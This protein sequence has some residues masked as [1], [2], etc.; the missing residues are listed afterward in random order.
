MKNKVQMCKTLHIKL[1]KYLKFVIYIY[2]KHLSYSLS[3]SDILEKITSAV[4]ETHAY[5]RNEGPIED[6]LKSLNTIVLWC[7]MVALNMGTR[8]DEPR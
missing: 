2:I 1:K 5:W 3:D 4:Q 7:L 8:D 6:P